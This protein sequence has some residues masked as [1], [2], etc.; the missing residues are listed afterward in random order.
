MDAIVLAGGRL[1][2][3]DPASATVPGGLKCLQVVGGRSMVQRSLDALSD[4]R[5]IGRVI[6]V[7]V[8]PE[9]ALDCTHP[10]EVIPAERD[11]IRSLQAAVARLVA[12]GPNAATSPGAELNGAQ[13]LGG[14]GAAQGLIVSA[15]APLVTGE[16]LDW[17]MDRALEGG[18]DVTITTVERAVMETR[19]PGSKRTYVRLRDAELCGGDVAAFRLAIADRGV[20]LAER[21]VR[22]R[23]HPWQIAAIVGPGT[24]AAL[25]AGRLTLAQALRALD[26]RLDLKLNVL[27]SPYAEMAMD[28][29]KPAQLA[30]VRAALEARER[31]ARG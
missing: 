19:F 11:M 25:M 1:P 4:A 12:A 16:M 8:P 17:M 23:K 14:P 9:T 13:G 5:G 29:D 6:V 24:L 30:L 31:D 7:G 20:E 26:E 28:V 18:A 2:L 27:V 3:E 22:A 21:L 10:L 15:D